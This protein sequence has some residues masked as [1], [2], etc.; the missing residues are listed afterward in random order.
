MI[1]K[2]GI[3]GI[4]SIH[5]KKIIYINLIP[6]NLDNLSYCSPGSLILPKKI[7]DKKQKKFLSFREN[8]KINFNIHQIRDPYDEH[9]LSV[10]DNSPEEILDA[11]I[12]MEEMILGQNNNN[13]ENIRLND[14]FWISL[15]DNNY[16][17]INY[18]KN[19]L[20]LSISSNFLKK[21]QHLF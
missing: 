2:S 4:S 21:N 16:D 15:S 9:N 12:E 20:K 13:D 7:F 10:I 14:L 18:L 19:D 17:K 11:V 3:S 1:G 8:I 5:R 6:L